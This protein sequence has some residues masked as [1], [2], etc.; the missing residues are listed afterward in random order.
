MS[1]GPEDASD[2]E[3]VSVCLSFWT[4]FCQ[5]ET[6]Q[7]CNVCLQMGEMKLVPAAEKAPVSAPEF[8]DLTQ[9][10]LSVGVL[11]VLKFKVK[12]HATQ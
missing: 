1:A 4:D 5:H 11:K 6:S 3:E 12:K 10:L 7:V 9:T 2:T 8:W